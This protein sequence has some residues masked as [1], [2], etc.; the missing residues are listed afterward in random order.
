MVS[1]VVFV[2]TVGIQT[3]TR[4]CGCD[5]VLYISH[6]RVFAEVTRSHIPTDF[7][8]SKFQY[9]NI[10][11]VHSQKA[12]LIVTKSVYKLTYFVV[13]PQSVLH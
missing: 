4:S 12:I 2:V 13:A 6:G 3:V 7:L 11:T 9:C 5:D 8:F 1:A 10:P